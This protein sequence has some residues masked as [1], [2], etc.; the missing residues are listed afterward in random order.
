[1]PALTDKHLH[2]LLANS[3]FISVKRIPF[4][5]SVYLYYIFNR[6]YYIFSF[7]NVKLGKGRYFRTEESDALCGRLGDRA[8]PPAGA[9]D[10]HGLREGPGSSLKAQ[11]REAGSGGRGPGSQRGSGEKPT[12]GSGW[13]F[14][15]R[16]VG[17]GRAPAPPA[18]AYRRAGASAARPPLLGGLRQSLAGPGGWS[19]PRG[20]VTGRHWL[21]HPGP[22]HLLPPR[23]GRAAAAAAS[24]GGA[25]RGALCLCRRVLSLKLYLS[26]SLPGGRFE[27]HSDVCTC[28][29]DA[30]SEK[31]NNN[32][33][34]A[35]FRNLHIS[36]LHEQG[37][38]LRVAA[39]GSRNHSHGYPLAPD[40]LMRSGTFNTCDWL[41][42]LRHW[43]ISLQ[44]LTGLLKLL[45]LI[46]LLTVVPKENKPLVTLQL[47]DCK[48][49]Q[50]SSWRT[51]SRMPSQDATL[52]QEGNTEKEMNVGSQTVMSQESLTFQDVA[53]D[54]TREEWDQLYPAQKNLYRDVMLENYRNLV[55]LGHQLYKPEVITQLEQ[56]EQWMMGRVS[57]PDTHPGDQSHIMSV[58]RSSVH[59]K[60]IVGKVIGTAMQKTAKV[61][62][63]RLV[64]DPYLLKYFNK[65]KTY[66]AH[67][68][69]QQCTIGDI[70]LLKAFPVPRTKHVK[71][72]LAEIVFKVG[73]VVDPVTGKRC[74]G[75]TY[76]ESPVDLETTPIAKNLEELSLSTTQ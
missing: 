60:W 64:L 11:F 48:E 44:G 1:M 32:S 39:L 5:S 53:V 56:E 31:N 76:L 66:F 61:R 3:N 74:A 50:P 34:I 22:H 67:D 26:K 16:P 37:K 46:C 30:F 38:I 25:A 43:K 55:A 29:I 23:S 18:H 41:L 6:Y 28:R 59:A 20:P 21:R 27:Y 54:F 47:K 68:A 73:Q 10:G 40:P 15:A 71:H 57:P 42:P 62:V 14:P 69:L 33:V 7:V 58:V 36:T 72:E 70:V 35:N 13:E 45:E 4:F 2:S 65:R 8:A 24:G 51:E 63:T 17:R 75:T 19:S 9:S 52:S 49:V 12:E